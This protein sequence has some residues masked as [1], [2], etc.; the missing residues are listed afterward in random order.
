VKK[1]ARLHTLR[2]DAAPLTILSLQVFVFF[3]QNPTPYIQNSSLFFFQNSF[4]AKIKNGHFC[5]VHFSFSQILNM[6]SKSDFFVTEETTFSFLI[7]DPKKLVPLWSYC[8][9]KC[10]G[11]QKYKEDHG[12]IYFLKI[13]I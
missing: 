8:Y 4:S 1:R 11:A 10:F 3:S 7:L 9:K 12:I 6:G 5:N 13:F 2:A